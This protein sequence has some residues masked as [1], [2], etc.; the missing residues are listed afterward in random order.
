MK[1]RNFIV[2]MQPV[3]KERPYVTKRGTF[4]PEKTRRAEAHIAKT[5]RDKYP[6]LKP[7][8]GPV[9]VDIA[10]YGTLPK[11]CSSKVAEANYAKRPDIDNIAKT[12]LDA[13]NGVA[14]KDDAYV[15]KLTATKIP[16]T[17]ESITGM[18]ISVSPVEEKVRR[19]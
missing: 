6:L 17:P 1:R 19:S 5:Y 16:R 13:L 4:T 18:L 12:V 2:I 7:I 8:M 14:Y 3:G 9:A 15:V 11:S 10:I